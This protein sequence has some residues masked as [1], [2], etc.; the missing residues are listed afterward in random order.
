MADA[1][2][3][4]E[5]K[6]MTIPAPWS[7]PS[8]VRDRILTELRIDSASNLPDAL[9]WV[10]RPV[11]RHQALVHRASFRQGSSVSKWLGRG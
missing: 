5:A 7:L 9:A 10:T 6:A 3:R 11:L 2:G 8:A 4:S 1:G